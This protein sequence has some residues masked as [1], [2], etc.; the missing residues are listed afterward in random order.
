MV[1]TGRWND[2]H[3]VGRSK[4]G[5]VPRYGDI[6]RPACSPD[7]RASEIFL[8]EYLKSEECATRPC[9]IQEANLLIPGG[10]NGTD[11]DSLLNRI[12]RDFALIRYCIECH[13]TKTALVMLVIV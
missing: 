4:G 13:G 2:T 3:T 9:C 5:L 11:I 6:P 1:I 10:G 8:W 12:V 7:L